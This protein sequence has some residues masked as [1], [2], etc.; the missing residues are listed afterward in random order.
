[1]TKLDYLYKV[2]RNKKVQDASSWSLY[3]DAEAVVDQ[4]A[5]VSDA[6]GVATFGE[7]GS[8]P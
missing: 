1:M 7:I 6:A 3:N 4:K 8:G 5:T 2:A